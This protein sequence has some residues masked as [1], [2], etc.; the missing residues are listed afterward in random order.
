MYVET[1]NDR[2][3]M[4]IVNLNSS[5]FHFVLRDFAVITGLK[6]SDESDFVSDLVSPI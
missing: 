3:D 5:E 1:N 2:D 4:F 6:C